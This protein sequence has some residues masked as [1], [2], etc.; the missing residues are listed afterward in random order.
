MTRL[1]P[2]TDFNIYKNRIIT[3]W[4][5]EIKGI[6]ISRNKNIQTLLFVDDQ[7]ILVD[8]EDALQISIYKLDTVTYKYELKISTSKMKTMDFK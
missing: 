2:F 5:D 3:E 4:K 1:P 7:V 8:S 6:K